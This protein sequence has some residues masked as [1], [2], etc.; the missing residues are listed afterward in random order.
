MT[1]VDEVAPDV[2]RIAT[3]VPEADLQFGQFLVRDDEPLLFE[4]G[5]KALFPAVRDAVAKVLDPSTIRWVS[6]SHF[7]ADE[8]GSLNEWLT[9]APRAQ[10]ACSLVGAI[11]SVNDFA[12]RPARSLADGE[13]F[14]T[15]KR[16]F[17]FLHTPHVPHCWEAG[18][19]FEETDGTLFCSDL[20][21]QNGERPPV[22]GTELVGLSR[23]SMRNYQ[24]GPFA[25]I[26]PYTPHTDHAFRR[27]MALQPKTL[28]TMHGSVLRGDGAQA[29]GE[30]ATIV[31]EIYA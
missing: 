29:L 6:F 3:Y 18:M 13:E 27:L 16:R 26:V 31:K 4:T 10:A 30:L 21:Q 24:K 15:G 25:N 11:V 20:L 2:F 9:V 14:S 7:E 8:C 23:E 12:I 28:A 1:A 5:M 22:G 19:L 17:R